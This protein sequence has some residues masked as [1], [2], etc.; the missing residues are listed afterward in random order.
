M[1]KNTEGLFS[2]GTNEIEI[3]AKHWIVPSAGLEDLVERIGP[4]SQDTIGY[5]L[6]RQNVEPVFALGC[7]MAGRLKRNG[8]LRS[9]WSRGLTVA[10]VDGIEI[11]SS[12]ARCCD[13]CMQREIQHK[14]A[15]QMQ[16]DMQY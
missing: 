8:V 9:E 13:A 7:E 6:Q 16:T 5:A 11:C 15:G 12:L 3:L 2:P 14:V 1:L 4:I 10:A